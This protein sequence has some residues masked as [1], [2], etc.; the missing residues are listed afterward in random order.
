MREA[1][2][3][4]LLLPDSVDTLRTFTLLLASEGSYA[5]LG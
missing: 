3:A 4:A 1:H 5:L 2:E